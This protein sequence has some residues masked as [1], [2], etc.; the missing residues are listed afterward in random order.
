V[1]SAEM[2]ERKNLEI[3][4]TPSDD[5]R[6]YHISSEKIRR[7]LGF[8]P[9]RTIEDGSRDLMH[10]MRAGKLVDP[11]NNIRYFNIKMMKATHLK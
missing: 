4:T 1:V 2:P 6:S 5:I 3:V 10:A 8:H 9:K 7:V 11:L